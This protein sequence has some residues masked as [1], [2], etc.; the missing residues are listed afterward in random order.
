MASEERVLFT[1]P[2]LYWKRLQLTN[3]LGSSGRNRDGNLEN[4]FGSGGGGFYTLYSIITYCCERERERKGS[5]YLRVPNDSFLLNRTRERKRETDRGHKE[6]KDKK[7][8]REKD[9]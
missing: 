8:D 1:E 4:A 7:I 6:T 5:I 2:R 3:V 9:R